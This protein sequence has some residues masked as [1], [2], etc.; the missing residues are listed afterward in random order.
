[1]LVLLSSVK[2]QV[3]KE[4]L[5]V[6]QNVPVL[7]SDDKTWNNCDSLHHNLDNNLVGDKAQ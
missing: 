5:S 4:H 2:S 1:M 6:R 3:Y 7:G